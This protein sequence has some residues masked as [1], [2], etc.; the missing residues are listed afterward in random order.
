M[1]ESSIRSE[2]NRKAAERLDE[3]RRQLGASVRAFA[4]HVDVP[5]STLRYFLGN[6]STSYDARRH[7]RGPNRE[8]FRSLLEFLPDDVR[9]DV[10]DAIEFE[11]RV[12]P[13]LLKKHRG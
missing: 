2:V 12:V 11:T 5:E 8:T 9:E 13:R 1:R 4:E 10:L 3:F 6:R 7:G